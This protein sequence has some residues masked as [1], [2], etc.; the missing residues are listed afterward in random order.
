MFNIDYR[1]GFDQ[2]AGFDQDMLTRYMMA[3]RGRGGYGGGGYGGFERGGY[4]GQRPSR[5]GYGGGGYGGG[6]RQMRGEYGGYGA[7][8]MR[9]G[10]YDAPT[11]SGQWR[12]QQNPY[13][14]SGQYERD[15]DNWMQQYGQQP[16]PDQQSRAWGSDP[17]GFAR[18]QQPTW[19]NAGAP[20]PAPR[21]DDYSAAYS[22]RRA[23]SDQMGRSAQFPT[24]G[25]AVN[26]ALGNDNIG[27]VPP[28]AAQASPEQRTA[29]RNNMFGN[30]M[31]GF[32]W[33]SAR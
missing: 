32:G 7:P 33:P 5:G 14:Q 11:G 22:N 8:M 31:R 17:F 2:D 3:Q 23:L 27:G 19:A 16:Q 15:R 29:N 25:G 10:M 4:A 9:R 26:P 20:G 24:M 21:Q 13:Y 1:G 30:A 28:G 12:Q 18:D 6:Y